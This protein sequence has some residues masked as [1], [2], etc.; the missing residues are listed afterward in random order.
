[1]VEL[2]KPVIYGMLV[3]CTFL[4]CIRGVPFKLTSSRR[5]ERAAVDQS[6]CEFDSE[7]PYNEGPECPNGVTDVAPCPPG[8]LRIAQC[9]N[10]IEDQTS[11]CEVCPYKHYISKY[12]RCTMCHECSECGM[13]EQVRAICT[14][15]SDTVCES[16]LPEP[17]TTSRGPTTASPTASSL[18]YDANPTSHEGVAMPTCENCKTTGS[19]SKM[20]VPSEQEMNSEIPGSENVRSSKKETNGYPPL[21]YWM[22]ALWLIFFVFTVVLLV[23]I[24]KMI[25][26][27]KGLQENNN[28]NNNIPLQR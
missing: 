26:K 21:T 3:M 13:N 1:M 24:F 9:T 19:S 17:K 14:A 12:N 18:S 16:I 28:N 6:A 2:G 8:Q 27:L 4:V 5:H 23:V 7:I 15:T 10:E 22:I 25:K 11:T 20:T